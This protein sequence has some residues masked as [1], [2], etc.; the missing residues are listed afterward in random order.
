MKYEEVMIGLKQG[1]YAPAYML[2]GKEPYYIDKVADYIEHN[3]LD[4][5]AR[6]FDQTIIY[7][8]DLTGGDVSA[9]IGAARG[10]AMM[11][12]YKVIIVKEAQNIKKWEALALYMENPQP[13]TI[14]VFCYKYGSP[15]KRLNLFKNWEKKGG[16]LMESEPL[17]DFQ[18]E[19]WIRE[20]VSQRNVELKEKGDEVR[21]DD[22]IAKILADSLGTDLTKIVG[23]L[24]KLVD[25]R[26]EGVKVIDADLVERNVGISKDFNVFELQSALIAGDV[27]KANRITQYFAASKDH[28][29]VKE[30]GILYGFFANLM[31]YHYLPDKSDRVAGPAL[32]VSPYFV[33]DYANAA[34]RFSAGKTFAI[35]GYF[36]E[37]D[38]RLKGI[39]N[40][41]AKDADLWKELIYKIMH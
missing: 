31:I 27:V 21:I 2:C 1:K 18:V 17:R 16:V 3:V 10:F 4:E 20:Y 5:M 14:L 32:G 15:D 39:N 19:K 12:G 23:A 34:R 7:G 6:E 38:A 22:K 35:I 13:S 26:P 36:R 41:S 24:Q 25:G 28:P 40:P 33:K 30:L 29:M 37:I 9:V 8:K 11:G